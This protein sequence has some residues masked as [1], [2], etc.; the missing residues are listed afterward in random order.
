MLYSLIAV[1]CYV[2]CATRIICFDSQ[3]KKHSRKHEIVA[4]LLI[5][6][7]A[8]QSINIIFLKDPVTIW[9]A[10]FGIVLCTVVFRSK[11]NIADIFK[12]KAL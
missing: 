12:S 9:D 6:A 1:V 10:F 7:F 8:G 11:G 4:M 5:A 3:N 2:L